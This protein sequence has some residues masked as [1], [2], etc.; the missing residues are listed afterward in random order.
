MR[1]QAE[2]RHIRTVSRVRLEATRTVTPPLSENRP[3][4]TRPIGSGSRTARRFG[5]SH[6]G[7]SVK[8]WC[9][10]LPRPEPWSP[11]RL[12]RPGR[13]VDPHALTADCSVG[14]WIRQQADI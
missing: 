12:F 14:H 6:R 10:N 13:M 1:T 5:H 9:M 3:G 7:R 2:R 4:A 8:C 11:H